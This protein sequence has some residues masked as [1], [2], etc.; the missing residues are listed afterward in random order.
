MEQTRRPVLFVLLGLSVCVMAAFLIYDHNQPTTAPGPQKYT[1]KID[2]SASAVAHY[3]QSRFF[4]ASGSPGSD[5]TAYVASLTDYVNSRF[6]YRFTVSKVSDLRYTYKAD[7]VVHSKF[8]GKES[9]DSAANVWTKKYT[10]LPARTVTEKASTLTLS[11]N[12]QIP[13]A[14]YTAEVHRFRNTYNLPVSSEVVVTY[15]VSVSGEVNDVPFT[16]VQTSTVT[17]PLE[18]QLY[19]IAVKFNKS[20]SKEVVAKQPLHVRNFVSTYEIP[21]AVVLLLLGVCLSLYGFRKQIIKPPYQRELARINRY[22]DGIIV[23]ARKPV[24]LKN[25]KTIVELNSFDDLLNIAE[26]AGSP[27]VAYELSAI[28]TRFVI[29]SEDTAYVFTLG[30][31]T[32]MDAIDYE[33]ESDSKP[34]KPTT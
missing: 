25:S 22:Y 23:R 12:V 20:Y 11:N 16:D 26:E 14:D 31:T 1:Y 28:A 5:N 33:E 2:Q 10:L 17:A 30:R 18:Q 19:K 27:I 4:D 34:S 24:S 7:A 13:F 29:T 32:P 15:T 3:T 8:S 6:N 9:S 21:V